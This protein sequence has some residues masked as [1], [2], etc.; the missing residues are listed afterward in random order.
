MVQLHP[1][2][3]GVVGDQWLVAREGHRTN[4]TDHWSL[5]TSH[6][7]NGLLVQRED[8]YRCLHCECHV[9]ATLA[10][11]FPGLPL[12]G[13]ETL[14]RQGSVACNQEIGVRLPGGP[15]NK[16]GSSSNGKTPAR[17]AGDPGSNPGESTETE[18]SRIRLAGPLC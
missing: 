10:P 3:L 5:T 13:P 17:Q 1:G 2:S 16:T 11:A 7:L 14:A 9:L 15:L 6:Y 8:A 12:V 18:G 4:P